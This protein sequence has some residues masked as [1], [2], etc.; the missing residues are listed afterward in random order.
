MRVVIF[1]DRAGEWRWRLVADNGR[2]IADSAEGYAKES[3]VTRAIR[4]VLAGL[5][6]DM[7]I[8]DE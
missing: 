4:K 6:P 2:I 1:E 8:G 5:T 7:E 3:N